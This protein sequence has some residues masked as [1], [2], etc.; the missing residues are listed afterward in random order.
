MAQL[1]REHTNFLVRFLIVGLPVVVVTLWLVGLALYTSSPRRPVGGPPEQPVEFSHRSHSNSAGIDC[2]FCHSTVDRS[3]FAGIPSMR[4]CY[5]CHSQVW[6]GSPIVEP[7]RNSYESGRP[8]VWQR[9]YD[10]PDHVFF[11]HRA[12][13]AAGVACVTCHGR[14]DLMVRV[15]RV[16]NPTMKWCLDCHREPQRYITAR[17]NVFD[18][19]WEPPPNQLVLGRYYVDRYRIDVQRLT[20][21]VTCHR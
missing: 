11:D 6:I 17:E 5:G 9:V 18:M 3:S 12:H 7:V 8:L 20:D 2:R 14:V 15:E 21:C 4:T 10:L 1:F 13:S 16:V 19:E